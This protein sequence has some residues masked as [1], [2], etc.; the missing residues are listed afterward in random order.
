MLAT[1]HKSVPVSDA[2][3][4]GAPDTALSRSQLFAL[5]QA[6]YESAGLTAWS[7]GIVPSQVT[8]NPVIAGAYARVILG[9][10]RDLASA[11]AIDFSQPLHV[12]DLGAGTGRLSYLVHKQLAAL[13]IEALWPQLQLRFVLCDLGDANLPAHERNPRLAPLLA[14][15]VLDCAALPPEDLGAPPALR[16]L[17]GG[18]WLTSERR[19][20]PLIILANY[21]FDS[22]PHDAFRVT[23]GQLE[24]CRV[25]L[26]P[27]VKAL[28]AALQLKLSYHRLDPPAGDA[29]YYRDSLWNQQLAAYAGRLPDTHFL[30]PVGP[31]RYLRWLAGLAQKRLLLLAADKGYDHVEQIRSYQNLALTQHGGFSLPVNFHAIAE[32]ASADGFTVLRGPRRESQLKILGLVHGL[33]DRGVETALAFAEQIGHTH[34]SDRHRVLK[35]AVMP[36]M[37]QPLGYLLSLLRLSQFDPWFVLTYKDVLIQEAAQ[38]PAALRPELA[39]DLGRVWENFFPAGDPRDLRAAIAQIL[40]SAGCLADAAAYDTAPLL[41]TPQDAPAPI[42]RLKCD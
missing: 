34:P 8:T 19:G 23:G 33:R 4:G 11:E 21:F 31:L 9:Y 26:C 18:T 32:L 41:T 1:V 13:R 35:Q 28:P 37:E 3:E 29:G 7:Q 15:G 25:A 38:G 36:A 17:R 16:L 42:P 39:E 30:F 20:N 27:P 22:I 12:L 10:L 5:Q 24:E 6:F 40:R 2:C 14:S